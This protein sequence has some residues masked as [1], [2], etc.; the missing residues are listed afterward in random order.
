[1][2]S[3]GS[4]KVVS[5]WFPKSQRG[6]A[7][8][9]AISAPTVGTVIILALGNSV[10]VPLFGGWR[11]ALFACGCVSMVAAL[12]WIVFAR[13]APR[14]QHARRPT[15]PRADRH[16]DSATAAAAQRA[17]DPGQQRRA[18]HAVA[19]HRQLAAQPAGEP[20]DVAFGERPVGRDLDGIGLPA[21]MLLPRAV[22]SGSRRYLICALGLASALAVV[23]LAVL[24][25][26]PLLL[27]L[28][29]SA[30]PAPERRR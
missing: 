22:A 28:V 4:N 2:I 17:A 16:V 26:L 21:G 15:Q 25:G 23:G 11:G 18:V 14:H 10:L 29:C 1:M 13:E 24:D 19:R 3:V 6:P 5:E 27:A 9:L 30:S 12:A 8:G 20:C 7:I